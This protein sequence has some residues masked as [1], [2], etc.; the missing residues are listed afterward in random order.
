MVRTVIKLLFSIEK[1]KTDPSSVSPDQEQGVTAAFLAVIKKDAVIHYG[2]C[3]HTWHMTLGGRH[4]K[5]QYLDC[6]AKHQ[7]KHPKK[8]E[9]GGAEINKQQC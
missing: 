8:E 9:E 1:I 5:H 4:F 6:G 7:K 3:A 2:P